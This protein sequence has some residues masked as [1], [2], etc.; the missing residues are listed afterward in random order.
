MTSSLIVA[1]VSR[2]LKTVSRGS[3]PRLASSCSRTIV[4]GVVPLATEESNAAHAISFPMC[5]GI[6]QGECVGAHFAL[7]AM[8]WSVEMVFCQQWQFFTLIA[9]S[10]SQSQYPYW[11]LSRWYSLA[12]V[13]SR[14]ASSGYLLTRASYA[15]STESGWEYIQPRVA[16]GLS[17]ESKMRELKPDAAPNKP[18]GEKHEGRGWVEV[19]CSVGEGN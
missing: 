8:V 17:I 2:V 11:E 4:A 12:D 7:I 15:L 13:V 19:G 1:A 10:P 16:V 9:G 18:C 3:S 5:R 6:V 14:C